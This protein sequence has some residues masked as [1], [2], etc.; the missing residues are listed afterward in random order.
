M[1]KYNNKTQKSKKEKVSVWKSILTIAVIFIVASACFGGNTDNKEKKKHTNEKDISFFE[2]I[3]D[4]PNDSTNSWKIST[5]SK[6]IDIN[7]YACEYCK[8]YIKKGDKVHYVVNFS[9]KTTSS[10]RDYG[11]SVDVTTTEY[12]E[13]EEHDASTLGEGMLY[14]EYLIDKKTGKA[15]K[16]QQFKKEKKGEK[17]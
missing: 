14:S 9:L 11:D 1:K 16:L 4:V 5:I 6:P 15:E 10:I 12:V 17:K 8:Q 7:K 3:L 13:G 2:P